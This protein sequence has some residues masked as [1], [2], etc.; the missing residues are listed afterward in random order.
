MLPGSR[1]PA[2]ERPVSLLILTGPL[3]Q[4]LCLFL[5]WFLF[6]RHGL[7]P[8]RCQW[9]FQAFSPSSDL[10]TASPSSSHALTTHLPEQV[11]APRRKPPCSPLSGYFWTLSQMCACLAPS[12]HPAFCSNVPSMMAF[13]SHPKTTLLSS[14]TTYPI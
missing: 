11:K 3:L 8:S 2:G 12:L 14:S 6:T 9:L 4:P 13:P 10:H 5:A 7:P 1:V